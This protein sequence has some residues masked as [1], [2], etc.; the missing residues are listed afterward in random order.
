M[1]RRDSRNR[2]QPGAYGA[3]GSSAMPTRH[4]RAA[5]Q[6]LA[7]QGAGSPELRN[8]TVTTQR[9]PLGVTNASSWAGIQRF[10]CCRGTLEVSCLI[11]R[12]MDPLKDIKPVVWKLLTNRQVTTLEE[13]CE[14]ID[15]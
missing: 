10:R 7:Y 1:L 12:E 14:L 8:Q 11:A 15:W 2:H 4:H 3:A 9:E 5:L 13:A 6:R